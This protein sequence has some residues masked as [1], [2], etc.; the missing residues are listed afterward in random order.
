MPFLNYFALHDFTPT[1]CSSLAQ[2]YG[3]PNDP[4]FAAY[5]CTLGLRHDDGTVKPAWQTLV[6]SA[7]AQGFP[8]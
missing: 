8:H 2:Y 4:A 6:D 7:A 1:F 3:D 5:L